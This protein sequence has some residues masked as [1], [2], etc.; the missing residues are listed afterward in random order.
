MLLVKTV[1]D[2]SR[3]KVNDVNVNEYILEEIRRQPMR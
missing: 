1:T 3:K 2:D